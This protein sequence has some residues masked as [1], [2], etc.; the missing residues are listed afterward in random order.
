MFIGL[1]EQIRAF[2][3]NPLFFAKFGFIG[4]HL[5]ILPEFLLDH[6]IYVRGYQPHLI[7]TINFNSLK[8]NKDIYG[9]PIDNR[10]N[11][12]FPHLEAENGHWSFFRF[13]RYTM[14]TCLTVIGVGKFC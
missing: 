6:T 13:G 5:P 11:T 7:Y 8:I 12:L 2:V 1:Y 4:G 10:N 3:Q 14:S 9:Y